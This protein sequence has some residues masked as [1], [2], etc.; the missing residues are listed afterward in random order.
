MTRGF[1]SVMIDGSHETV[2]ARKRQTLCKKVVD[3][4]AEHNCVV[5]GE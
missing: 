4:A 3:Y 2:T 1:T 5:E